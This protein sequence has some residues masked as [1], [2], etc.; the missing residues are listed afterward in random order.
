MVALSLIG[1][2]LLALPAQAEP[3][4]WLG[5]ALAGGGDS[6]PAGIEVTQV[7]EGSPAEAAGIR[8]GDRLMSFDGQPLSRYEE[9]VDRL[10]AEQ[11]GTRSEVWV[12]R[13]VRVQLDPTQV[14]GDRPLLGVMIADGLYPGMISI[15][16]VNPGSPAERAGLLAGDQLRRL[17]GQAT[18]SM[19]RLRKSMSGVG[20]SETVTAGISR[21]L[22]V[23]LGAKPGGRVERRFGRADDGGDRGRVERRLRE[24]D[25]AR[26]LDR[27]AQRSPRGPDLHPS[28]PRGDRGGRGDQREH[29]NHGDRGD[30]GPQFRA[31]PPAGGPSESLE[32][33]L[34]E[35]SEGLRALRGELADLR[36]ELRNLRAS[37]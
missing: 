3:Q 9:L 7:L 34:R 31:I 29:R 26:E 27:H 19:A 18:P 15:S 33:E 4:A 28:G 37:R 10:R 36:R 16:E 2:L 35:L 21:R 23:E 6:D 22:Q 17:D 14:Q 20:T 8:A 11:P 13:E 30:P 32:H 25:A 5:V 24:I 12:R 1:S